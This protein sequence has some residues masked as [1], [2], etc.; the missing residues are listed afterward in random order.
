MSQHI[1]LAPQA[2]DSKP[3]P[4][5]T[6][7]ATL[8]AELEQT[9]RHEAYMQRWAQDRN[10]DRA[11]LHHEGMLEAVLAA[12]IV[13][14][15]AADPEDAFRDLGPLVGR[16]VWIQKLRVRIAGLLR[17]MDPLEQEVARA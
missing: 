15:T 4:W 2:N 8:V 7:R 6:L 14:D 5:S 12:L 13:I 9:E 11:A 16:R 10:D 1:L 3:D 17:E